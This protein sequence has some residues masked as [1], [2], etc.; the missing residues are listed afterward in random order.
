MDADL[1]WHSIRM[2]HARFQLE[3]DNSLP[4]EMRSAERKPGS[5]PQGSSA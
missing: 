4:R 3:N 1:V 5:Y 2:S